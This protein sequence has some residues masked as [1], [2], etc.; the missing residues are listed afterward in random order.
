MFKIRKKKFFILLAVVLLIGAALGVG[1]DRIYDRATNTI[2]YRG[3]QADRAEE[4]VGDYAKLYDMQKKIE[5]VG[6]YD[7]TEEDELNGIYQGLFDT[8]DDKY[9]EYLTPDQTE[10]WNAFLSGKFIGIGV[11]IQTT[12]AGEYEVGEVLEGGPAQL[13]G[14]K[15]GDVI[16]KVDGKTYTDSQELVSA[17]RG[18]AGTSVVL[19]F[20]RNGEERELTIVRGEVTEKSVY[21]ETLEEGVGYIRIT[22]FHQGT[23]DEFQKALQSFEEAASP[24]IVI[25]LRGNG[26]GVME[27]GI[28]I[29]DLLLPECTITYTENKA[30]EKTY[31]NSDEACTRLPFV[32]LVNGQTASTAE[33]LTSAV[34]DNAEGRIIGEKT[35]G[36]G[37]VQGVY[38]FNDGSSYKLTIM[39]YYSPNG[40]E[41]HEKGI[42]PDV[43]I[44]PDGTEKDVQLDKAVETLKQK[45]YA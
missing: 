19:T 38:R 28:K 44:A 16:L 20:R 21:T 15:S 22:S 26:G 7:L 9:A 12:V 3:A 33:I 39:K 6:L 14:M 25:D 13:A 29:A 10:E 40:N 18:E 43:E 35:F 32:L 8:L 4:M 42:Q 41:I 1:G 11:T 23:S 30:G 36:K 24:G 27:E 5:D 37:I 34:K 31:H 2:S 45:V 17:I